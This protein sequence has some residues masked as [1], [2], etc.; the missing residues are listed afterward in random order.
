MKKQESR[1]AREIINVQNIKT[2]KGDALKLRKGEWR[3]WNESHRTSSPVGPCS[4]RKNVF[5][6]S[7]SPHTVIPGNRLNH[8]RAGTSGSLSSQSTKRPSS[9]A[10]MFRDRMRSIR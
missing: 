5:T 3:M 2:L 10:A 8:L 6:K 4:G 7:T 9:S 1:Q